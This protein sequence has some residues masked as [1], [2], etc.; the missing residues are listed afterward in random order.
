M[1]VQPH[2]LDITVYDTDNSTLK[3]GVNITISNT[4]KKSKLTKD[5]NGDQIVTDVN[6][7]ALVDLANLPQIGGRDQYE[8]GDKVLIMADDGV[9]SDVSLYT[10]VGDD[11][12]LTLYLNPIRLQS[13]LDQTI[14]GVR[15]QAICAA[16][17]SSSVYEVKV[18]AVD[19]GELLLQLECPA[20]ETTSHVFGG[21]R[22]KGAAGGFVVERENQ[23]VVVT[24]TFK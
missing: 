13:H 24:A 1:P 18:Y 20:N 10:V 5:T 14:T 23:A 6:G 21:E 2:P 11:K 8:V 22:G 17:T 4:T 3:S 9:N 7:N 12:E 16:N 15:L 19:T